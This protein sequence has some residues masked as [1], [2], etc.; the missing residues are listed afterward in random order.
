MNIGAVYPTNNCGNV[1]VMCTDHG[2]AVVRFLNTGTIKEF[3]QHWVEHGCIRDPYA[4]IFCG[5]ACVGNINTKG[6]YRPY[7][8]V[9]H[10]MIDRCYN[11]NN[12]RY[13]AYRNTSVSD[14]WLVFENFYGDCKTIDGFDEQLFLNGQLTL[15][16]DIKQRFANTKLYSK[17]TC[18]WVSKHV[19]SSIQDSQ[20]RMFFAVAPDGTKYS[21]YNITQ[22][23]KEHSLNRKNISA[24]LHGRGK[25]VHGWRFSYEEIV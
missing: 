15:D 20:Q 13:K 25:T 11:K 18:T 23:A 21:H 22:F 9:W 6:K 1:C 24:V 14:D 17:D 19:N 8:N 4:K 7:Y 5:V 12:K 2:K 16:K 3:R 10:D